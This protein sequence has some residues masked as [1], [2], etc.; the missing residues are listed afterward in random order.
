MISHTTI[1]SE[2]NVVWWYRKSLVQAKNFRRYNSHHHMC[3][4][5]ILADSHFWRT[6]WRQFDEHWYTRKLPENFGD[7]MIAAFCKILCSFAVRSLHSWAMVVGTLWRSLSCRLDIEEP[8]DGTKGLTFVIGHI[9]HP[10]IC[11]L[12]NWY[13]SVSSL[14]WLT[15]VGSLAQKLLQKLDKHPIDITSLFD[16]LC[17]VHILTAKYYSL[18]L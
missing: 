8:Q 7:I 13:I 10:T 4:T 12:T 15:T 6:K 11:R 17:A 3:H 9:F 18:T 16:V 1:Y 2:Q 14:T 5:H